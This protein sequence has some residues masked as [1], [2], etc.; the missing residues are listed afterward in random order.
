MVTLEAKMEQFPE[1]TGGYE[2]E[3]VAAQGGFQIVERVV[4]LIPPEYAGIQALSLPAKIQLGFLRDGRLRLHEPLEVTITEEEEGQIVAEAEELSEF[5]Y[6]N[7]PTD[8]IT[9]LQHTIAELYFT[10]EEEQGRLG[11]RLQAVW[12]ALQAKIQKR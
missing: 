1:P 7:N 10:L 4:A 11:K 6:G 3:L 9:D 12:D 2:S 5:G 8:A